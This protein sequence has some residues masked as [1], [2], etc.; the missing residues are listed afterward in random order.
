MRGSVLFLGLLQTLAFAVHAQDSSRVAPKWVGDLTLGGGG[1]GRHITVKTGPEKSGTIDLAGWFGIGTGVE[2]RLAGRWSVRGS[3]VYELAGWEV[4][5]ANP[6]ASPSDQGDRWAVC[7]GGVYQVYR[8]NRSQFTVQ[9]GAR[10]TLGMDVNPSCSLIRCSPPPAS[11]RF[12]CI[13]L[14]PLARC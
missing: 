5:G 3:V 12:G 2:H 6:F 10:L 7:A 4:V 11:S 1:S 13:M 9:G 14:R 8:G